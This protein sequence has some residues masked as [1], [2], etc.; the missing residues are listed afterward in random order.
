MTDRETNFPLKVIDGITQLDRIEKKLD[1]IILQLGIDMEAISREDVVNSKERVDIRRASRQNRKIEISGI[2]SFDI[3]KCRSISED[4]DEWWDRLCVADE[5]VT[6]TLRI[7]K[8]IDLAIGGEFVGSLNAIDSA[9]L[10]GV[11]ITRSSN[12]TTDFGFNG[13]PNVIGVNFNKLGRFLY[14]CILMDEIEIPL[15]TEWRKG[16]Y[17]TY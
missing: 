11:T 4:F 7:L 9:D 14:H 6:L 17:N 1:A 8:K 2:G 10:I 12:D 5:T 13:L 3:E 16:K 15:F